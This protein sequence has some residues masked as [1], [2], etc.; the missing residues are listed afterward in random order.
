MS[1]LCK[2]VSALS[3]YVPNEQA[4]QTECHAA[5]QDTMTAADP[6]GFKHARRRVHLI[7][8]CC[9][10]LFFVRPIEVESDE[11]FRAESHEHDKER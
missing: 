4:R 11:E 9:C 7:A 3:M 6:R 8:P 1:V 5:E 2:V 10:N